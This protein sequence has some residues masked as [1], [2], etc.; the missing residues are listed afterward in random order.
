MKLKDLGIKNN[1]S[2]CFDNERMN[3]IRVENNIPKLTPN[4]SYS[5]GNFSML[6]EKHADLQFD[7]INGTNHRLNTILLRTNWSKNYFKNKLILECGC[8]A[9]PDTEILLGLGARVLSVDIAGLEVANDNIGIN[10]NS[11]LLQAS[12]LDLPLKTDFFDI[13]FCHRVLQHTPNPPQ[14]LRS[15][16][17]FIKP[18]GNVFIHSYSN[19]F[20]QLMRWKYFLR[21]FTTR[22]D[23]E[24]LYLKIKNSSAFYFKLT[25]SLM[26]AG[27]IGKAIDHFFIPFLNYRHVPEFSR[28]DDD[29]IIEYGVHDTFDALSPKYD[30][31][32][33][34]SK[35]R[36]IADEVLLSKIVDYE[37]FQ[38]RSITLLRGKE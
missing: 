27:K 32:I 31:P 1:F 8:G 38:N 30:Q 25:N 37:I 17:K 29:W 15:L 23:P 24:K 11:Q 36:K 26:K 20:F 2:D 13:V 5:T 6:R 18:N 7:S 33:S 4:I 34:K 3:S 28:K 19:S 10:K 9:G 14:V 16:L 12:L 21:P 22:M 35:L